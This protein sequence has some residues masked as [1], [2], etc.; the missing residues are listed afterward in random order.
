MDCVYKS[1]EFFSE[2]RE[3]LPHPIH[4]LNRIFNRKSRLNLYLCISSVLH[5]L[6]GYRSTNIGLDG[7]VGKAPAR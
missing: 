6:T 2:S 3:C 4:V 5:D 7:L 1:C